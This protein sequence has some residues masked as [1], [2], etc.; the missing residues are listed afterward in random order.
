MR[1]LYSKGSLTS[2]K[3]LLK[4][5]KKP[6]AKKGRG[7]KSKADV[8]ESTSEF[9]FDLFASMYADKYKNFRMPAY[10]YFEEAEV[11]TEPAYRVEIA[12]TDRAVCKKKA[13]KSKSNLG[14]H[15]DDCGMGENI[16]KGSVK[17]LRYDASSGY[18][19]PEH[20]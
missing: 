4:S 5:T 18:G 14:Q 6:A 16:R 15:H 19:F 10:D 1:D 12:K 13:P 2:F 3:S 7:K 17:V 20:L 11:Q 8:K 9:D